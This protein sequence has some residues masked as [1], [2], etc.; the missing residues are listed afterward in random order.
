MGDRADG[1]GLERDGRHW[2][3]RWG[4]DGH[5]NRLPFAAWPSASLSLEL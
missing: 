4:I 1:D 2:D 3:G 5:R